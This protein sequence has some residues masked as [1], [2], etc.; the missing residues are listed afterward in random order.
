MASHAISLCRTLWYREQPNDIDR[1]L[2]FCYIFFK[3]KF[4]ASNTLLNSAENTKTKK[5][6]FSSLSKNLA[7]TQQ[8]WCTLSNH[9][10][11]SCVVLSSCESREAFSVSSLPFPP[12]WLWGYAQKYEKCQNQL[13]CT[14]GDGL[15][16]R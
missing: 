1:Q 4:K 10:S 6:Y 3:D 5:E 14:Q 7:G 16:S 13:Y 12:L 2:D 8:Q 15:L 11:K 9:H